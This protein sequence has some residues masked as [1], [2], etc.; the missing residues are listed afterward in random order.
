MPR[1]AA[2][3]CL[4]DTGC[5]LGCKR[6]SCDTT[7]HWTNTLLTNRNAARARNALTARVSFSAASLNASICS[8]VT[9]KASINS[10]EVAGVKDPLHV[11]SVLILRDHATHL[12][13]LAALAIAGGQRSLPLGTNPSQSS[14]LPCQGLKMVL[15]NL[16]ICKLQIGVRGAI[17]GHDVVYSSLTVERV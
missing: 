13:E 5:V 7:R 17:W 9:L 2:W 1:S 15:L 16:L 12:A 6:Y 14:L 3:L 8:D 10:V 11:A 4:D